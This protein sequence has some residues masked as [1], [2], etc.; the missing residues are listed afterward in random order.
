M[1]ADRPF[2]ITTPIYYVNDLPHLGHAYTTVACDVLARFMRL[3]GRRVRFLTGTDE[4][5]QKVEQSARA[6]GISPQELTDRNSA[7]FREMTRLLDISNDDFIRTTEPRHARAVQ[8]I[9]QELERRGEIYL[10][11][12]AGWYSVRDEAFYDESELVEGK[13]PTGAEV[14]WLEEENYF[15]RLSAWQDRLLTYY[16]ANPDAIAPRS[17]RNEVISFVKSGLHDLSISRTSFSWGIPVPGNPQ[18]VIYVWLDALT[19]YI[20]TVGYPDIENSEFSTLWPTVLH[21]VGK[22]IL[23]FHTVYWPAF[24]MAAGI[25]P[26]RRVFAHGWWTVEG[27]KMSKS[28]GN[29]IP[30]KQLVDT[31]GLDPVRYFL[32]R[33]LPFGSDGDFSH[34]AVV[35]RLNGDLANDFGN[36]AQRVLVMINRNCEACVPEPGAFSAADSGLLDAVR[37]LVETVRTHLSEQGFH[38][39]LEAIWRVVGEANRYVDEQAPWALSRTDP[40]RMRTVLYTLAETIRGLAI[41][42]QPFVPGAAGKL[43]DQLAVPEAARRFAAL[44]DAPLE[45]RTCL[46]KPEGVFP[47]FVEEPAG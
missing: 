40:A 16:D 7:G 18:H 22:D 13:A 29:F 38:L 17:R 12:F 35:S 37:S 34:R 19:N 30:P 25:E 24:L 41:L 27:Q 8:A 2:F 20:T 26:P 28:L 39:A 3:D 42:T 5:G 23:R 21:V 32:L 33:E 6:A 36:L 47:R 31:Y 1:T 45:P 14:E 10:G 11:P 4:H 15:F 9:W 46:P 44:A 43:L